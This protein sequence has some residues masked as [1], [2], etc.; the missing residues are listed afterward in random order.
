MAEAGGSV[1]R[2]CLDDAA[3]G[4]MLRNICL[5]RGSLAC[6]HR[7]C[8]HTWL[9][10]KP[11][12]TKYRCEICHAPMNV[13]RRCLDNMREPLPMQLVLHPAI[14][15][16][17]FKFHL[18]IGMSYMFLFVHGVHLR[19]VLAMLTPAA[20]YVV[21][22]SMARHVVDRQASKLALA[23]EFTVSVPLVVILMFMGLFYRS[24]FLWVLFAQTS[25]LLVAF[26]AVCV[27]SML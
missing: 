13:K 18:T 17:I 12:P 7:H 16:A 15:L 3:A 20:L 1:C 9:Q 24:E 4:D 23:I 10:T 14:V 5:C 2:I 8:L 6:V 11:W 19:L 26:I 21:T 25:M 27:A 22:Y